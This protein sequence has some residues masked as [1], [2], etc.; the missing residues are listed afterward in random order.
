[1]KSQIKWESFNDNILRFQG[2]GL[3]GEGNNYSAYQFSA[4]AKSWNDWVDSLKYEHPE[5]TYKTVSDLKDAY[6][7]MKRRAI[8]DATLRQHDTQMK[9]L[10]KSHTNEDQ[11]RLFIGEFIEPTVATTAKAVSFTDIGTQTNI[12]EGGTDSSVTVRTPAE[13][14]GVKRGS[15][16]KSK[17]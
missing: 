13:G 8:K 11:N 12:F 10:R 2:A 6:K 15:T 7:S 1:M 17:S 14:R 3:S 16:N 4:F 9:D 5:V